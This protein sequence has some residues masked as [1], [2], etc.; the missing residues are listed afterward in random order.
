LRRILS[1]LDVRANHGDVIAG[2]VG[3]G[4]R[5]VVIG[6]N[7]VQIG[8][9]KVPLLPL[10]LVPLILIGGFA[11]AFFA[12]R[13]PTRMDGSFNVAVAE[14]GQELRTRGE[15]PRRRVAQQVGV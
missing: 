3:E 8:T 10:L 14:F 1:K 4:A 5:G 12:I 2:E 6:K 7:I 11:A 15:L 13:G 9:L